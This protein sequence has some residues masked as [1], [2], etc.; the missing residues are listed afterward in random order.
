MTEQL[1]FEELSHTYHVNGEVVPSV[2]QVI[3]ILEPYYRA[4]EQV[5]RPYAQR[6]TEVHS[7]TEAYDKTPNFDPDD[8]AED[9]VGYLLAW[10][11]FR[12][13][14]DFVPT[15]IEHRVYD[16]RFFY[17]GTI[18]RV[19][20]VRG[21]LSVVDIKTGAKLGP[22][23]GVQLAAYQHAFTEEELHGRYT[24]QLSGDGTYKVIEYANPL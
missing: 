16:P 3:K 22:A 20:T 17:A 21:Q 8:V 9:R 1:Q 10:I 24:V 4:S 12:N 23:V 19:G 14:F 5:L 2:T 6:G 15:H 11:N 7:L 13:D 18:D